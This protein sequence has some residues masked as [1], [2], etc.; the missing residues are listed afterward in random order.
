M[1]IVQVRFAGI[2]VLTG[3]KTTDQIE[4]RNPANRH[5][6]YVAPYELD[7]DQETRM[8]TVLCIRG[9]MQGEICLVPA[10][11]IRSMFPAPPEPPHVHKG[12]RPRKELQPEV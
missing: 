7:F 3:G 12:G 9:P 11:N 8:L 6:D 10:E 5:S 4:I 2:T 1:R